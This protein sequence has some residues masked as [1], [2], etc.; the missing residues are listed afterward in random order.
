M[1]FR[2]FV[3]ISPS[4]RT[5]PFICF[6]QTWISFTQRWF[7]SSLVEID[8]VVLEKKIIKM[9]QCFFAMF[10]SPIDKGRN[11][12]FEQTWI[13]L[14]QRCFV[15]SL[16]EIGPLVLEKKI[17]KFVNVILQFCNYLPLENGGALHLNRLDSPFPKDKLYHVLLK[18]A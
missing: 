2:N 5:D 4:K 17:L 13:T 6:E 12:S 16:V 11:P 18:L 7:V 10:L 1:Y 15:P 8:P 14:T 9:Y 3:I